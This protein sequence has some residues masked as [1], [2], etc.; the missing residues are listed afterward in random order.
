MRR[1]SCTWQHTCVQVFMYPH[2]RHVCIHSQKRTHAC[3]LT[4]ETCAELCVHA[5]G[6]VQ[7]C[8]HVCVPVSV[9]VYM[10]MCTCAC[11]Y[12]FEN[13]RLFWSFTCI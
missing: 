9:C 8:V 5:H 3:A 4:E 2:V 7:M 12:V 6:H 11:V 10:Y 1:L 13:V